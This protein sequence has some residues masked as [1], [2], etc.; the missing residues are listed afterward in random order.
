M[1]KSRDVL[2]PQTGNNYAMPAGAVD[3][4]LD[5]VRDE[6]ANPL[7]GSKRHLSTEW[8]RE[9]NI[10][11]SRESMGRS[12]RSR[13]TAVDSKPSVAQWK[14]QGSS[15]SPSLDAQSSAIGYARQG[16]SQANFLD[17][18]ASA[19]PRSSRSQRAPREVQREKTRDDA[20]RKSPRDGERSDRY[21]NKIPRGESGV[22][23]KSASRMSMF[24]PKSVSDMGQMSSR[25][26]KPDDVEEEQQLGRLDAKFILILFFTTNL[27][28]S[29]RIFL[30]LVHFH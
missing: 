6:N 5:E 17:S 22:S 20:L 18:S 11:S 16:G 25:R 10:A 15:R 27:N 21:R 9:D 30:V 3:N 26:W 23:N 12:H 14:G 13:R 4:Y 28:N 2:D 7:F 8:Q 24:Q 29:S 19:K 1:S